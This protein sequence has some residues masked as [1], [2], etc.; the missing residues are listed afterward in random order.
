VII[1]II[2]MGMPAFWGC[3][4]SKCVHYAQ[5]GEVKLQMVSITN[6]A[7]LSTESVNQ[8]SEIHLP[9]QVW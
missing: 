3:H 6:L 9:E 2:I 8:V 7:N 4:V 1:I 5:R